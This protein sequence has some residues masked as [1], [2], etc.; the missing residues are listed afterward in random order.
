MNNVSISPCF[1]MHFLQLYNVKRNTIEN[2]K[3]SEE[4]TEKEK[5][6]EKNEEN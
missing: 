2:V 3:V 4:T 5:E 6:K 1:F